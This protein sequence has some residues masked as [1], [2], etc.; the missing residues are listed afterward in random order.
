MEDIPHSIRM[1]QPLVWYVVIKGQDTTILFSPAR[2]A[3]G[4]SREQFKSSL[5]THAKVQATVMS[6]SLQGTTAS[7]ADFR[8]VLKLV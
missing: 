6:A 1:Q 5:H 2:D 7:T 4:S 3:K 8:N